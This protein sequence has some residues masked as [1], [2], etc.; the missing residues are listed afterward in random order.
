MESEHRHQQLAES[1]EIICF[2]AKWVGKHKIIFRSVYHDGKEKMLQTIWELLDETDVV[3]HYNG[4]RFDVPHLNREF[5]QAEMPPPAPFRQIDL[6]QAT[7]KQFRFPSNKL[8]YVANALG[9][10]EKLKHE[11]FDL[12][13]R[14]MANEESAWNLM[15]QYNINDVALTELLYE[16]LLP[17]IPSVPS[18]SAY[19]EELVCPSC[20][21]ENLHPRG[22]AYT[23]QSSYQ[24][25]R[26]HS[27]G[28]WSRGTK[29]LT[30]AQIREIAG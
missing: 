7:K 21:S 12:W 23:Q 15:R 3:I 1:T 10:G 19:S 14:C 30:I 9:I 22:T 25:Y 4:R 18:Q 28:R 6:L 8:D 13:R 24:R 20:G 11:G 17:W 26:C 16:R 29:S 5:L 27:C 2:A